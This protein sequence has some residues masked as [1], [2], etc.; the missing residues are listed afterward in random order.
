MR[1]VSGLAAV[2][3]A[4]LL[5][6]VP[7]P[8][9]AAGD[10]LPPSFGG[11][12]S[13]PAGNA[14][15]SLASADLD[16]DGIPDL[17]VTDGDGTLNVLQG[18]GSGFFPGHVS[19]DVG[20]APT[21]VEATPFVTGGPADLAVTTNDSVVTLLNSGSGTFVAG[22]TFPVGSSPSSIAS[23]DLDGNGTTDLL[24][25]NAG[26]D[27]LSVLLGDGTGGF[28]NEGS[29]PVGDS[30]SGLDVGDFDGD[31]HL[32]VAVSNAGSNT[33][34]VLLGHGD[35]TFAEPAATYPTGGTSPSSLLV[36][37]LDDNAVPD[38]VVTDSGSNDVAFLPGIGDGTFGPAVNSTTS[39]PAGPGQQP[40][41]AAAVDLDGDGNT[42]VAVL[43]A[44]SAT[45]GLLLGDGAGDLAPTTTL[46]S[47]TTPTWLVTTD[48][49]GDQRPDLAVSSSGSDSAVTRLNETSFPLSQPAPGHSRPRSTVCRR[50]AH[51][52]GVIEATAYP[53]H[54]W[55]AYRQPHHRWDRTTRH[56]VGPDDDPIPVQAT[57]WRLHRGHPL[58][59][60][61]V[62][63]AAGHVRRDRVHSLS[64]PR[65]TRC[66]H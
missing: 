52:A 51:L 16:G 35:G 56:T 41:A 18:N 37:D 10:A 12:V 6:V 11:A 54:W 66:R 22:Q 59:Y 53:T 4:G 39:T 9:Q 31:G 34:S 65:H 44:G 17:V 20:G 2:V 33:V 27:D 64:V 62:V 23:G 25:T 30:P 63:S 24:V 61:L 45:I 21:S 5:L 19:Y 48:L 3:T 28:T 43:N 50:H 29:V 14:P 8:S 13:S 42:D 49:D 15:S 7:T 46:G 32:D 58:R 1:S 60:R 36:T 47:G 55:F 38:L 40:V 57:V 26:D